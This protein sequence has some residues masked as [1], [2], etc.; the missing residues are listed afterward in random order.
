MD[1]ELLW[2]SLLYLPPDSS[3]NE[4]RD[5]LISQII[6]LLSPAHSLKD[7]FLI[8]LTAYPLRGHSVA[9]ENAGLGRLRLPNI[10]EDPLKR[11]PGQ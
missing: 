5:Q 7:R 4:V 11:S 10:L 8:D 2:L 6:D 9:E 1:S 3:L